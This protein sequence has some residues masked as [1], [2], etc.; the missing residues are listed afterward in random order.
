MKI[1]G[2]SRSVWRMSRSSASPSMSGIAMSLTIASK[3]FPRASV[4]PSRPALA[5]VTL[6]PAAVSARA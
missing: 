2:T 5:I 1:I 4:A 3:R 6:Y